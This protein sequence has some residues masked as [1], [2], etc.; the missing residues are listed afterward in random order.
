[1]IQKQGIKRLARRVYGRLIMNNFVYLE[2]FINLKR[3]YFK[4][5]ESK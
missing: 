4:S 2:Y 3:L 1:M 5:G